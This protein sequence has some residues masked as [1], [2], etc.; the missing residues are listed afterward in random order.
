VADKDSGFPVTLPIDLPEYLFN[1]E[2]ALESARVQGNADVDELDVPVFVARL[3]SVYIAA[4]LDQAGGDVRIA[5]G[6]LGV[7]VADLAETLR[8]AA[9]C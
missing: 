8:P 1:L 2:L 6:L 5:A 4:A 9:Q 7:P 3:K